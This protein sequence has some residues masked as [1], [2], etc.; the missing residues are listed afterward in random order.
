LFFHRTYLLRWL[1]SVQKGL[2]LPLF[3]KKGHLK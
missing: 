2:N 3:S 1:S